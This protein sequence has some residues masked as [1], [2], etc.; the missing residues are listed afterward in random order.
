MRIRLSA[1]L[2]AVFAVTRGCVPLPAP[3]A[4]VAPYVDTGTGALWPPSLEARVASGS[5]AL[6]AA[7][8]AMAQ[9]SAAAVAASNAQPRGTY[10]TATNNATITPPSASSASG[11]F[12]DM[13]STALDTSGALT[14]RVPTNG[15]GRALSL[16]AGTQSIGWAS[17]ERGAGGTGKPGFS[18]GSGAAARDASVFRDSAWTIGVSTNLKVA[19]AVTASQFVGSGT[20]LTG[21]ATS[22]QLNA[23]TLSEL[24]ARDN[25]A[26]SLRVRSSTVDGVRI[27][28]VGPGYNGAFPVGTSWWSHAGESGTVY[29]NSSDYRV[30]SSDNMML[31]A[32]VL[33]DTVGG[34][35]WESITATP[36]VLPATLE[37]A[38]NGAA[39]TVT[40]ESVTTTN[41]AGVATIADVNSRIPQ[42]PSADIATNIVWSVTVSNGHWLVTGTEVEE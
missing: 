24:A 34:P 13:G 41:Y 5:L 8:N 6:S 18:L 30:V 3:A 15:A 37:D 29:T 26:E 7:S 38:V 4:E 14:V 35:Q 22:A 42:W 27:S 40:F 2:A 17:F 31:P 10:L 21:V 23:L 11:L 12:V 33:T 39:G 9:A 19:G 1:A 32:W 25:R 28:A 20:G 16:L 36:F